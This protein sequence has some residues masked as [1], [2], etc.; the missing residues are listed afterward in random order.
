MLTPGAKFYLSLRNAAQ[1][2]RI[3]SS[4]HDPQVT[5]EFLCGAT[6]STKMDSHVRD[7]EERDD[8]MCRGTVYGS[9]THVLFYTTKTRPQTDLKNAS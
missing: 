6:G 5:H 3:V 1:V 4:K 8:K 2:A 9:A 7:K